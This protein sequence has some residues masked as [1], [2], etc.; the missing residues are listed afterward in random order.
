MNPALSLDLFVLTF[1]C[2]KTII[3]VD[4]FARH[5][6]GALQEHGQR[7]DGEVPDRL[8]DPDDLDDGPQEGKAVELPDLV[9]FSLQE[10]SPLAH[11]FVGGYLLNPYLTPFREALNLAATGLV[12]QCQAES[13]PDPKPKPSLQRSTSTIPSIWRRQPDYPY[14]LVEARNVGMTAILLFARKPDAIHH[15]QT[16]ECAF[17]IANMGNKGAV[18]LRVT[19]SDAGTAA[20]GDGG[21]GLAGGEPSTA[22]GAP[23]ERRTTELTFVATHLAAMEYNLRRR[24]A[25][26]AT[27][28]S[29]CTFENPKLILPEEFH[30]T[31]PSIKN[32]IESS[33]H[34][35]SAASSS[36]PKTPAG[37]KQ[38]DG[39]QDIPLPTEDERA[40][41]LAREER[42]N[43]IPADYSRRLHNASI[44]KP[45]AHLF[46]AGDLNYR[47]HTDR[48]PALAPFPTLDP[49]NFGAFLAR[50]QLTRER[51]GG[52]TLH[53]LDEADVRFPPT[54]KIKHLSP[55]RAADAV[56]RE[57]F[58]AGRDEVP[59]KWAPHRWPGWCDRILYLDIPPW[60]RQG[61]EGEGEGAA[62]AAADMVVHRYHSMPTMASSDHQPVYLRVS[63]PLLTP[64]E[65]SPP[66]GWEVDAGGGG[67]G[68]G[69]G[70]V[71]PRLR[72]PVPIDTGAWERRATARK[73]EVMTGMTTL[74]FSTREGAV[75]IGTVAVVS[76]LS[77][78]LYQGFL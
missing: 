62:A 48:P 40:A 49:D 6:R 45:G 58:E 77:W 23:A 33:I 73:R 21:E 12:Q 55:D 16:A 28:V 2:A 75:V 25:N 46:V 57:G 70:L 50:D 38:T 19:Y 39:G 64:Q 29:S 10:I 24:N 30:T 69:A 11:G 78:W 31:E 66:D 22:A 61:R 26:W 67:G 9:V 5:L 59:W 42:A 56:N 74:F 52:R 17:G 63:V 44:F 20:G 18:A 34:S 60:A 65:L 54:Y 14:K 35:L 3:D 13:G 4:V 68:G 27:I 37:G 76:L 51:R 41:F 72:L 32:V 53:G 43:S 8:D 1:N 47:I 7:R 71:D 36:S 15:I